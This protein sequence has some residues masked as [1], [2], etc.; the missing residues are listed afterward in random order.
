MSTE[1]GVVPAR[2]VVIYYNNL[3]YL[4]AGASKASTGVPA[5]DAVFMS[6]IKTFRRL[7]ENEFATAEPYKIKIIKPFTALVGHTYHIDNDYDMERRSYTITITD[8]A[9]GQVA[10]TL[11]GRPNVTSFTIKPALKFLVD[12]G[13]YPGL[14]PTEVPSYGWRYANVHLE[15]YL[16]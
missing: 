16:N 7:R 9:T 2:Y 13:F 1:F 11:A 15:A 6:S 12:M 10:V 8:V 14:V 4:F 5:A 3:A